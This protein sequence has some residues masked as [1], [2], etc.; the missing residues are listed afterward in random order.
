MRSR[1]DLR[2]RRRPRRDL[3]PVHDAALGQ[4][5]ER[6]QH[7]RRV[8]AEHRAAHAEAVVEAHHLALGRA[9]RG[10]AAA[11]GSARCR[12]PTSCPAGLACTVLMIPSVE[13]I[14]SAFC[15]T[16]NRHSGMDDHLHARDLRAARSTMSGVKRLCTEQCPFQSRIFAV[17]EVL[18][19]SR[20]RPAR[21]GPRPASPRAGC[22]CGSRCCVRGAGRGRTARASSGGRPSRA[23]R[24]RST[25]CRPRRRGGP[26]TPSGPPSSSC[27]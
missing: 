4:V 20:R 24:A 1:A 23:R 9:A 22:P 5:L 16:S 2:V 18:A 19:A 8:D 6:P 13:P 3:H 7:V 12:P 10:R 17:A 14:A 27:T 11:P 25:T 15:A 26:R 21:T